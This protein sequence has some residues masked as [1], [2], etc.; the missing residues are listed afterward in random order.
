VTGKGNH[1]HQ[2]SPPAR[3]VPPPNF[4]RLHHL[5]DGRTFSD[6]SVLQQEE[7]GKE[8]AVDLYGSEMQT[9]A[10]QEEERRKSR[11]STEP[12]FNPWD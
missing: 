11:K 12:E 9:E 5:S 8:P 10:V 1:L 6:T 2:S 4:A 3:A 7:H